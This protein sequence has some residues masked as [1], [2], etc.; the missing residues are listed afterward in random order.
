MQINV[1]EQIRE[2]EDFL[3]SDRELEYRAKS[4]EKH[5]VIDFAELIKFS[6]ELGTQLLDS[7]EETF[8]AFYK[9]I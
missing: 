9:A 2:F 7:P 8:K 6:D 5:L 3:K 1:I 4:C